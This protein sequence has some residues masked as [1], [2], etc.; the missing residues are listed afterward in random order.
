LNGRAAV[1]IGCS[2]SDPTLLL[3]QAQRSALSLAHPRQGSL[4]FVRR[5]VHVFR[6]QEPL[7]DLTRSPIVSCFASRI[8]TSERMSHLWETT[9]LV[10]EVLRGSVGLSCAM[11]LLLRSQSLRKAPTNQ[12]PPGA[13]WVVP[14][15]TRTETL[16]SDIARQAHQS[17]LNSVTLGVLPLIRRTRLDR[18]KPY[19][20]RAQEAK[21]VQAAAGVTTLR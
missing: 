6:R 1:H 8:E 14:Q 20:S 7:P 2:I 18:V 12:I 15:W 4:H 17:F 16:Q 11:L 9:R 5:L 3:Q 10:P 19:S 21:L 13:G